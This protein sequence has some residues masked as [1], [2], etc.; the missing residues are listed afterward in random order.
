MTPKADDVKTTYLGFDLSTQKLK[1]VQLSSKLEV[2]AS[3]EVK[4]DSDLPEFRT[5]GGANFGLRNHEVFVQP[6]MW[7]KAI[8]IVLD[9]LVMQGAD[10]S[11][12]KAIGGSAQ[13][14]GSLY[15]SRH[16]VQ[17]LKNLDSD[18]FLHIQIDDSAFTLNRTPI[19]MDGST[20]KQC[21]EM[22]TAIGG[23]MEMVKITG[24]KCYAR[25]TGPQIRK[26][27]Q[28]RSHAYE[29]TQRISLVSSFLASVFLGDIAPIDYG[30]ASGM[31]LFDIKEKN[32]SKPCLNSCAPDLEER[33]GEPVPTSSIIGNVSDF[34][35]QRFG[36]P[37]ECKVT[38]F[39]GDNLSALSGMVTEQNSL[40]MSLGT[41]DTLM[42]NL[43]VQPH[44]EEG[45]VLCHPTEIRQFMGLLCFRN[46]S[47]VRD[48]FNKTEVNSDWKKFNE[49]LDSTPRG[50]YGNMAL[51]FHSIEITPNVQG[52]L[53]WTRSNS[54]ETSETAKG[55]QKFLSPQ[56]EIRALIEGQMLH[57]RAVAADMG[58]HFGSDTKIIATGG[59]SVNKSILQ[60]VSDVFNA[61]VFVQNESEAALFGA[62]YRA[63]YSLYLNSIKTSNDISNGNINTENST[64]TPLSYHDYI[65][66]FIPNLLKLICEPSKDCEQ[67][68]APMLERYRKMAV[69]LA[70][71]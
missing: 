8:D 10:L 31:N 20:E 7:V 43:K 62:A 26:I 18:K 30:D 45:H 28:E 40:V 35:V 38:A 57:K 34:F 15:W 4:F 42:M 6:V 66:Q 33:L 51:H 22:E 32:W 16:G 50:N 24:S 1:A 65:M 71:N 56:T 55:V 47:L 14:H 5:N 21:I 53:R 61:P 13:Q 59:A 41:S 68:Y 60:V 37:V 11:T 44:L 23:R 67:I 19:W 48:Y 46:G 54:G 9:R 27:Y 70:Q 29:E 63:K 36:F 64:L 17:T 69:V 3:A 39:T 12:V 25:F 2:N 49:L 52:V 58:F